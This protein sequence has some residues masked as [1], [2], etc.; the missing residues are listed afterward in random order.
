MA[1]SNIPTRGERNNNPGNIDF[2]S[3]T[4]WQGQVGLETGV[5]RPR[6]IK[7]DTPENGVR[8]IAKILL[9]YYR[10][11]FTTI[12]QMINRWAPPGEND[13]TAYVDDVAAK[14]GADPDAAVNLDEETLDALVTALILHENGRCIY[15]DAVINGGVDLALA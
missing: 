10:E 2:H 1:V 6:F 4:K 13:T 11:G 5:P 3:T 15:A 8:A 12:R 9:N 14:V 7:F